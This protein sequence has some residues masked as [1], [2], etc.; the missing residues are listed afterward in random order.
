MPE[1]QLLPFLSYYGKTNWEGGGVNLPRPQPQ[2]RVKN[3]YKYI[4]KWAI[5]IN[6]FSRKLKSLP[7]SSWLKSFSLNLKFL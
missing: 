3:V 1:L 5:V 4:F 6:Q 2:I 7:Q